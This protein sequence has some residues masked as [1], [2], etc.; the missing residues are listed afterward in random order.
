[1][2]A[3]YDTYDYPTYWE[4][5]KYEHGSEVLALKKLLQDIPEVQKTIEIGGG[6]GR[7][8][9]A[10]GYRSKR[11]FLTDPSAKLLSIARKKLKNPKKI[12]YIQ[13][14][15][16]NI[17]KK[18]KIR[19]F[20]LVLMVRVLHHIKDI[21]K[22]FQ[23]INKLLSKNGYFILEFANKR[24]MKAVFKHF[25]GGDITYP[26]EISPID[27]RSK[28]SK[29]QKTLPFVNFH[30]DQINSKLEENGFEIIKTLSVSNIRSTFLKRTF[31]TKFLLEIED[32]LQKPLSRLKFGPSIFVLAKKK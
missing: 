25:A 12:T 29:K 21:D 8:V 24:H 23:I 17:T 10:Y 19:N 4:T 3:A 20:D 6:F 27:I 32:L 26:M 22:A 16:E 28:K 9:D 5:R 13:S 30:P 31:P 2:P 11:I 1:M 15:L 7:L 14:K 18:T